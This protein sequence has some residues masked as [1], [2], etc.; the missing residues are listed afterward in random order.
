MSAETDPREQTD[1]HLATHPT[2][3][4]P[5]TVPDEQ[6][7][8]YLLPGTDLVFTTSRH[9]A[10]YYAKLLPL[11]II[12]SPIAFPRM[13]FYQLWHERSHDSAAH[14]WLRGLLAD[15]GGELSRRDA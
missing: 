12:A 13:R 10:Q 11:A 15:A 1:R 8:P 5:R 9:F 3:P 4:V 14:R 7:A 6:S 2:I